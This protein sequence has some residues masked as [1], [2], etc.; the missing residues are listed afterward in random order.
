MAIESQGTKLEI[1]GSAEAA[2]TVTAIT[3]GY[4]TI[5]TSA[6]HGLVDGDVV[7]AG[8]FAGADAGD[9][10]GE[11]FVVMFATDDTVAIDLDSTSLTID[12]NTDTATLTPLAWVEIGEVV[13]FD[14]PGGSANMYETT[15]LRSTAKEKM[16][17]LMDEGQLTLSVNWEPTDTGQQ[18][19]R[20]ART[21]RTEKSFRIT[22]SDDSTATFSGY[23]MGMSS[24]GG[25][26]NKV[27]G[28]ITIEITGIVTYA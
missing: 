19:A 9:I 10:N 6:A 3:L 17:G 27:N 22:Y 14:G 15:H 18:A 12:D 24:S 8:D 4:P 5:L 13:D 26:D 7:T 21:N 2:A 23:V 20:T 25:V 16:V 28:S 1:S 11:S